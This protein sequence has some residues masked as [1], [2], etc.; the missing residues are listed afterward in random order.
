LLENVCNFKE[1]TKFKTKCLCFLPEIVS[2]SYTITVA[3]I[4]V[5]DWNSIASKCIGLKLLYSSVSTTFYFAKGHIY[6]SIVRWHTNFKWTTKLQWKLQCFSLCHDVFFIRYKSE[7]ELCRW[8]INRVIPFNIKV[9]NLTSCSGLQVQNPIQA[10]KLFIGPD[11]TFHFNHKWARTLPV[12]ILQ[13]LF[14]ECITHPLHPTRDR[15]SNI[16]PWYGLQGW[17]FTQT[18]MFLNVLGNNF[19][20]Y[21]KW[22]STYA[23]DILE[24]IF[25]E[26]IPKYRYWNVHPG[27]GFF[28][29]GGGAKSHP[30]N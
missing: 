17:N 15:S 20:L 14:R 11:N 25:I 6:S 1:Y 23:L 16:T 30:C 7:E 29:E 2:C 27:L 12:S 8:D 4:V 13:E 10:I 9:C 22:T 18:L 28:W 26:R 5:I 19:D 3:R 24:E 21:H